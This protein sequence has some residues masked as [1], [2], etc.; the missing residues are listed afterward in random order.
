MTHLAV[1]LDGHGWHPAAWRRSPHDADAVFRPGY[2]AGLVTEAEAGLLDLVTLEDGV[3]LQSSRPDAL[4]DRTDQVRGRLDALLV[5]TYLAPLT[6]R[7]GL[8]PTC[9]VTHTE[10]FHLSTAIAT[11]DHVSAGRAGWRPQVSGRAQDAAL[12]GRRTLPE[13]ALAGYL[14]GDPAATALVR[15][16]FDEA[17]DVAE[18]VG[19]LW[20]SWEDDAVI[21]DVSTGRYVDRDK[22]HYIDFAGKYFSVKGPSITPRPPQGRPPVVALAHA[23][24]PYEFAARSADVVLVTPTDARDAA[25]IVAEVRQAERD[26]DRHGTPLI[27]LAD[28]LVFLDDDPAAAAGRRDELDALDG[29]PLTS[30]AA[31]RATSPALLADELAAWQEAGVAG[32]R[33]R[34]GQLPHDL[35]QITRGLVPVLQ[36]RD[37]FRTA[38]TTDTLRGHLGLSRPA[39]RY[40]ATA[41]AAVAAS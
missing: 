27:V 29:A 8:V 35:E 6:R 40:A 37:G 32:F 26:V 41:D 19:A 16:L 9:T 15:D 20:D 24:I 3:G 36:A 38:W 13:G 33:L 30:D 1:A 21:R 23:R 31:I 39:G 7:I 12:F 14:A 22:L 28:A 2:W 11:L 17:A 34:P 5:A 25:R 4:D 18:A 10:P